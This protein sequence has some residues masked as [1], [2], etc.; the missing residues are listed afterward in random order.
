MAGTTPAQREGT[1]TRPLENYEFVG[2]IDHGT[3]HRRGANHAGVYVVLRPSDRRWLVEKRLP[4]ARLTSQPL[5]DEIRVLRNLRHPYITE[6]VDGYVVRASDDDDTTDNNSSSGGS[7]QGSQYSPPPLARMPERR[8]ASKTARPAPRSTNDGPVPQAR[9]YTEY[10]SGGTLRDLG[11]RMESECRRLRDA[12]DALDV[13]NDPVGA[14]AAAPRL[15][16]AFL[17]HVFICMARALYYLATGRREAYGARRRQGWHSHVHSDVH[18]RNIFL[19]QYAPASQRS[20]LR[21]QQRQRRQQRQRQQ[22][23]QQQQQASTNRTVDVIDPNAEAD[24]IA[25]AAAVVGYPDAVLGDWGA[26]GAVFIQELYNE[27]F[28]RPDIV[29]PPRED[30]QPEDLKSDGRADV[31]ALG[32]AMSA[33]CRNSLRPMLWPGEGRGAAALPPPGIDGSG[34][35]STYYSREL[36]QAIYEAAQAETTG[37]PDAYQLLRRLVQ[38]YR[39]AGP[40]PFEPLPAWTAPADLR[41]MYSTTDNARRAYYGDAGSE[42]SYSREQSQDSVDPGNGDGQRLRLEVYVPPLP[43]LSDGSSS[44]SDD[45]DGSDERLRRGR[46][47]DGAAAR[48]LSALISNRTLRVPGRCGDCDARA[49]NVAVKFN[50]SDFGLIDVFEN[51]IQGLTGAV[52]PSTST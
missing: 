24:A 4:L 20:R 47:I 5:A 38:L 9:L 32:V 3:H 10:C 34:Y 23:Q 12:D 1:P 28:A 44:E 31:S 37:H 27:D 42:Q 6:Y 16:E 22:Q 41:D 2:R 19:R 51:T 40:P 36:V 35:G 48:A 50:Q 8:A 25:R 17:W 13:Q 45:D 46:A 15:P 21:H 18:E 33:M 49:V 52:L 29:L 11:T 39:R 43:P 30:G 26:A 7:S 14:A